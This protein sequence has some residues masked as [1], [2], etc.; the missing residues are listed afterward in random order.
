[1]PETSRTTP[2]PLQVHQ[3]LSADACADT[4]ATLLVLRALL[5][6]AVRDL[7][8]FLHR[9]LLELAMPTVVSAPWLAPRSLLPAA[10][11]TCWITA[12][13]DQ[14]DRGTA[15][16]AEIMAAF[17][18]YRKITVG[19]SPEPGNP[20]A[21]QLKSIL[22]DVA[23]L[24]AHDLLAPHVRTSLR[25]MLDAMSVEYLASHRQGQEAPTL[26]KREYLENGTDSIGFI[27]IMTT[28]WAAMDAPELL[29]HLPILLDAARHAARASRVANDLAGAEREHAEGTL[30]A[31]SLGFTRPRLQTELAHAQERVREICEPLIAEGNTPAIALTRLNTYAVR[32]YRH[33]DIS[34]PTTPTQ[35]QVHPLPLGPSHASW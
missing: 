1:M 22:H 2:S 21:D 9:G 25:L 17:D 35:D 27:P 14:A 12:V 18:G 30:N 11:L 10:R 23:R 19:S 26:G 33:R 34:W 28:L 24:P 7:Q 3:D 6:G 29:H 5:A 32:L 4:A 16:A 15:N 13:D 31:L 8:P 20:I